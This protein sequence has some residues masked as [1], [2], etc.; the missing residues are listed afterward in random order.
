MHQKAIM[1]LLDIS[2]LAWLIVLGCFH[3]LLKSSQTHMMSSL[4]EVNPELTFNEVHQQNM[5]ERGK[6]QSFLFFKPQ[7]QNAFKS[8]L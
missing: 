1:L 6:L 2:Q 7:L 3:N 4:A 5:A 8:H